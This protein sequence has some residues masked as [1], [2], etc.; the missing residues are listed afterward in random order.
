MRTL[1]FTVDPWIAWVWAVHVP[2][3]QIFFSSKY[4]STKWSAVGWICGCGTGDTENRLE[5]T[6]G[7]STAWR[8]LVPNP[9]LFKGQL[10]SLSNFQICNSVLLIIVTTLYSTSPRLIYFITRNLYLLTPFTHFCPLLTLPLATTNLF[11]AQGF[12][13]LFLLLFVFFRW[14]IY[15]RSYRI[16]LSLSDLFHLA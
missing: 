9:W 1:R 16:C 11:S 10:Y 4:H 15:V 3:M 12:G 8:V 2:Y 7:F 6:F 14:H 13:F 5:I